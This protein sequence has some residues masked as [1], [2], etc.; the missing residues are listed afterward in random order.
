MAA[1]EVV[2]QAPS[3]PQANARLNTEALPL[4]F[5]TMKLARPGNRFMEHEAA[6]L[7]ALDSSPPLAWPRLLPEQMFPLHLRR[8]HP[9]RGKDV[10]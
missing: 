6:Q 7:L 4:R 2:A 3:K 8:C 5:L 1:G 9:E 10:A